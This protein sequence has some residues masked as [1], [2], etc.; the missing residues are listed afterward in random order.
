MLDAIDEFSGTLFEGCRNA[1]IAS[2][3]RTLRARL[4]YLRAT[5]THRQSDEHVGKSVENLERIIRAMRSR[6]PVAASSAC[7]ERV[8]HSAEVALEMLSGQEQGASG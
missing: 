3:L 4:Y 8:R 5:T 2:M 7:V 1:L 6:D